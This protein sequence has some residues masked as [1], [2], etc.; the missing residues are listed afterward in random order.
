[1][2]R[3]LAQI[4]NQ[5]S[6]ASAK[7]WL[8]SSMNVN[9]EQWCTSAKI[10]TNAIQDGNIASN[11]MMATNIGNDAAFGQALFMVGNATFEYG[12]LWTLRSFVNDVHHPAGS[13]FTE[14]GDM[15]MHDRSTSADQ[16]HINNRIEGHPCVELCNLT[17]GD[18]G[19]TMSEEEM[20][21]AAIAQLLQVPTPYMLAPDMM[22]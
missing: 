5:D 22:P 11:K 8:D 9:S 20:I 4:C 13:I 16:Q 1:M 14:Y 17:L 15:N 19:V 3:T 12:T 7:S 10:Y 2:L 21:S 6:R 18:V